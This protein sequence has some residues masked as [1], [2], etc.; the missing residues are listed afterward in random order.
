M[1]SDQL[2]KQ[3][4]T[5]P[6]IASHNE[7]LLPNNTALNIIVQRAAVLFNA[8]PIAHPTKSTALYQ[9]KYV[10]APKIAIIAYLTTRPDVTISFAIGYP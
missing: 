9:D 7:I 2:Q 3:T 10:I 4:I 6:H 1:F 5:T 8:V